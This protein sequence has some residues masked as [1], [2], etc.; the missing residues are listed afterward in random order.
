[1]KGKM[2][3]KLLKE[4]NNKIE[5]EVLVMYRKYKGYLENRITASED[6]YKF[7]IGRN[8]VKIESLIKSDKRL[9]KNVCINPKD[10]IELSY[11][12]D[13]KKYKLHLDKEYELHFSGFR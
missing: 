6:S 9:M 11:N 13:N 10:T 4:N 7:S 12:Y 2:K 3:V 8:R 5:V 1:M